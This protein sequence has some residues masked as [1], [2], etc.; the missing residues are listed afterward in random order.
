VSAEVRLP[1]PTE[2]VQG[3]GVGNVKVT[4]TDNG[5]DVSWTE[6]LPEDPC[7]YALL[8]GEV[9]IRCIVIGLTKSTTAASKSTAHTTWSCSGLSHVTKPFVVS[10]AAVTSPSMLLLLCVSCL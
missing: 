7:S 6:W 5:Y 3:P 10:Q 1:L 4:P 2:A 9:P 8:I